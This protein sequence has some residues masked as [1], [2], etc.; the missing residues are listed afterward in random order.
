[1]Y[2][3]LAVLQALVTKTAAATGTGLDLK[4]Q[5]TRRGLRARVIITNVSASAA[6]AVFTPAI[7]HSSDNT[8]FQR[9]AQ[10]DPITCATGAV[11]AEVFIPFATKKRYVRYALDLSP[12]TG[13]PTISFQ[14][15]LGLSEPA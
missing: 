14:I 12:T 8:T 13:T 5:S 15:D 6:G 3:A 9:I 7:D 2:D 10:A 11:T 1:M 4:T